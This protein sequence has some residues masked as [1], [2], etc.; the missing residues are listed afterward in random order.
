V[1]NN[2]ENRR[3]DT[4]DVA[5]VIVGA[6]KLVSYANAAA[7]RLLGRPLGSI[8]GRPF[9]E[10]LSDPQAADLKGLEQ[11]FGNTPGQRG[12]GAM[13]CAD[14]SARDVQLGF[15]PFA[16]PD[17]AIVAVSIALEPAPLR[18]LKTVREV[19]PANDRWN[20]PDSGARRIAAPLPVSQTIAD[21]APPVAQASSEKPV[22]LNKDLQTLANLL[23]WADHCLSSPI[24]AAGDLEGVRARAR[25]VLEEARELLARC[26]VQIEVT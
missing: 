23:R 6:Q 20:E 12:R 26:R 8:Q 3:I 19:A 2:L 21:V 25:F 10:L 5:V 13:R 22:T 1:A 9:L 11:A 4:S 17:G 15:E 16:A 7:H 24:D 18:G 14:G